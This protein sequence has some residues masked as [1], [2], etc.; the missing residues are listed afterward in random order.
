MPS[1]LVQTPQHGTGQEHLVATGDNTRP[2]MRVGRPDSELYL[3]KRHSPQRP[4][5][6]FPLAATTGAIAH[7]AVNPM[8]RLAE[9]FRRPQKLSQ[10]PPVHARLHGWPSSGN[11]CT[12]S[13]I[14]ITD[15][16]VCPTSC[17]ASSC[18]KLWPQSSGC[19][20]RSIARQRAAR[21][22]TRRHRPASSS[23]GA[24]FRTVDQ[25]QERNEGRCVRPG[26][27]K[28]RRA[29]QIGTG[30]QPRGRALSPRE[31]LSQQQ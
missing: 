12:R 28:L 13:F 4:G 19:R 25:V 3:T 16:R 21:C 7:T 24:R 30:P 1:S 9:P 31:R 29:D 2:S 15:N 27:R 6:L 22:R 26:D 10:D 20:R 11:I 8:Q 23:T 14:I 5:D 18:K 17:R